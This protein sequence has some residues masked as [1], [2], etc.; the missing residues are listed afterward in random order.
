MRDHLDDFYRMLADLIKFRSLAIDRE[1][2]YRTAF[3][4]VKKLNDVGFHVDVIEHPK[5][6][7]VILAKIEGKSDKYLMFYN[8]YDVQPAEPL[9]EW[10][11]DPFELKREGDFLYGRGVGD[12]KGN[13]VS[14][15]IAVKEVLEEEGKLPYGIKFVLEGEEEAGSPHLHEM[16]KDKRD[17]FK[18]VIGVIWEFGGF[19]KD[20]SITITLGL[21]GILYVE[22]EAERLRRDAHS[23]LAVLLPSATWD[24]INFLSEIKKNEL[25]QLKSFR[26]GIVDVEKIIREIIE[27]GYEIAFDPDILKEE[28]GIKEFINKLEGEDALLAYYGSPTFNIDGFIAGYTGPG[29]KTVL[30]AKALVKIDFRLVPNQDSIKIAKEFCNLAERAS[31]KCRIHSMTE[32]AYTDFKNPFVQ[33]II[34]RLKE[35]G[36]KIKI[37]PWSPASGP[38]HI[39]IK[40]FN[41]PV[42]AG[43]GVSYWSSR[44]HA[45]NENIRLSDVEKAMKIIKALIKNPLP[46]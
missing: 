5:G 28:Y 10:R 8:H 14:R 19:N 41:L 46:K 38:M 24:L 22:L 44:H 33:G 25:N 9:D 23:S 12:N 45:P 42:I 6:N 37:A 16:L 39:F 4:I 20:G 35:I 1:E 34:S 26:G 43:I 36:E 29:T 11:S 30:P 31:I 21:K 3:T 17:F 13:I 7:P 15:I 40:Y 32:P 2:C 27:A 18:D